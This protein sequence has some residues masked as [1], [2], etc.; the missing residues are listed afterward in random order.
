MIYHNLETKICLFIRNF[1]IL[2]IK[3]LLKNKSILG[4][5]SLGIF[6]WLTRFTY[7]FKFTFKLIKYFD[8]SQIRSFIHIRIGFLKSQ[9]AFPDFFDVDYNIRKNISFILNLRKFPFKKNSIESIS[10]NH[11][12]QYFPTK[13]SWKVA[14]KNW[15]EKLIPGGFLKIL[16]NKSDNTVREK[17]NLLLKFLNKSNF[18]FLYDKKEADFNNSNENFYFLNLFKKNLNSNVKPNQNVNLRKKIDNIQ[19]VINN[20][21]ESYYKD[22][23]IC[24]IGRNK[25]DLKEIEKKAKEIIY[26]SIFDDFPLNQQRRFEFGLI[27]DSLEYYNINDLIKFF[28]K[29]RNLFELKAKILII[30]PYQLNFFTSQYNQLF[31]KGIVAQILDDNAFEI[32]W[33][34]LDSS[35]KTIITLIINESPYPSERIPIKI[36]VLGNL[37]TRYNQLN[38]FWDGIIRALLKLGYDP[39]LLDDKTIPFFEIRRRI[40]KYQPH[41]IISGDD[42]ALNFLKKYAEFFRKNNF[43]TCYWYR[44]VRAAEKFNFNG[45]I[46]YLFLTNQGQDQ[47][48][49]EN[50]Q[51][52]KIYYMPQ[53]CNPQFSHSNPLILEKY[54][55]GFAGQVDFGLFHKERTNILLNLKKLF[56]VRI[57]NAEF[58]S[59]SEFYSQCRIVFGNDMGFHKLYGKPYNLSNNN[60]IKFVYLFASNRIFIS[61]GCGTCFFINYFPGIEKMFKNEIH[62]V[63]YRNYEDLKPLIEKY[64][65]N[66]EKRWAIKKAALKLAKEKHTHIQ[67]IQNVLDIMMGKTSEFYGFL[68]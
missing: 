20:L 64:L 34:M 16:I 36:A 37:E 61:I 51:M 40:E 25:I 21:K 60:S 19:N 23:I 27:Y 54:D 49:R 38:S 3:S 52:E 10:I 56:N 2:K 12:F 24:V 47:E 42:N 50:Y 28:Q 26:Y 65:Q 5:L 14:I 13:Y 31:N 43:C 39:L 57:E 30:V 17:L 18:E 46:N 29:L 41:Y 35:L 58:N 8:F 66:N 4:A 11:F 53:W 59:I 6:R 15:Y 44:N 55:V 68:N 1:P 45:V 62:I 67:R 7:F 32:K 22:K 63:W 33:M 48:Y 9:K